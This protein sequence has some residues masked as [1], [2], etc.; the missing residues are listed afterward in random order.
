MTVP[1]RMP[2]PAK[3]TL[4]TAPQWSRPG[5]GYESASV[6]SLGVRP[7]SLPMTISVARA[8]RSMQVVEQGGDGPV[9]RREQLVLQPGEDVAVRV[10]RL[11]VAEVDLD[12]VD[13]GLDQPEGHQQRPAEAVAP[14]ALLGLRRRPGSRRRRGAP[15]A[16]PAARWPTGD[17][18]RTARRSPR[19]SRAPRCWSSSRAVGAVV[20]PARGHARGE[21]EVRGLVDAVVGARRGLLRLV[22]EGVLGIGPAPERVAVGRRL[23][24]ERVAVRAHLAAVGARDHAAGPVDQPLGQ[25]DRRGQVVGPRGDGVAD[26]RGDRRPVGRPG[27][28]VAAEPGVG[29]LRPVS[30]R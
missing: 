4:C 9:G 7:N 23:D 8:A 19:A 13:P 12:Q 29:L 26:D 1:P 2:P 20:E 5:P 17:G 10:P 14:V 22:G 24:E 15:R 28:A 27:L 30:M 11:V 16:R 6:E 25:H 21:R 18:G 3:K